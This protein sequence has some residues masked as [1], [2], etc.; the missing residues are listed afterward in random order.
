L[1]ELWERLKEHYSGVDGA[2]ED[3]RAPAPAKNIAALNEVI[4]S[5]LTADLIESLAVHDGQNGDLFLFGNYRLTPSDAIL[6]EL[7]PGF[8]SSLLGKGK[9]ISEIMV[10][11]NGG[12]A[13]LSLDLQSGAI[14]D[15]WEDG[16][17]VVF[18][19]FR[20]FFEQVLKDLDS[21]LLVFDRD[22]SRYVVSGD[23]DAYWPGPS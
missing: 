9:T 7:R 5:N 15:V 11:D 10:A 22:M 19:N 16:E 3:L 1:E 23:A 21:G 14:K 17:N 4:G 20:A 18:P 13:W 2:L 8:L 6:T 12:N